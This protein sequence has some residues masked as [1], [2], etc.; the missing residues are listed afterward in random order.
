MASN[1]AD[2]SGAKFLKKLCT[3]LIILIALPVMAQEAVITSPIDGSTVI[4]PDVKAAEVRASL[5]AGAELRGLDKVSGEV[6]Q[7]TLSLGATA[8]VGKIEV[9]LGECRYPEDN[10]AGEAFAW[11]SIRDPRRDGILFEG[12]MVASSPA[13]NALDHARYDVWVIRCTIA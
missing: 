3:L 13:L 11:L 9:T 5:G 2:L 12:W 10:R 4:V 7:I 6:S 1:M 8:T